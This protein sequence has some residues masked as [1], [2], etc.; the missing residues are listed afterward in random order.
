[1]LR[2]KSALRPLH[3]FLSLAMEHSSPSMHLLPSCRRTGTMLRTLDVR[4]YITSCDSI[5]CLFLFYFTC[6]E[7]RQLRLYT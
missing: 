5:N 7:S 3:I 4:F 2:T 6:Q 1:M